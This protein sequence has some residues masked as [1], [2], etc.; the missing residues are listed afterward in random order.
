MSLGGGNSPSTWAVPVRGKDICSGYVRSSARL[1]VSK[2][3]PAVRPPALRGRPAAVSG[4][5]SVA[6]PQR[7][8]IGDDFYVAV[9]L[10]IRVP[11][12]AGSERPPP[13]LLC[14]RAQQL[15]REGRPAPAKCRSAGKRRSGRRQDRGVHG[16][17]IW[18][19]SVAGAGEV[20]RSWLGSAT[21]PVRRLSCTKSS[22]TCAG[23]SRRLA[24]ARGPASALE[25]APP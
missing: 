16:N 13:Q 17:G 8:A 15:V 4:E 6:T 23:S 20:L 10:A 12:Q 5:T 25:D 9:V 2:A 18:Q 22:R 7:Q 21:L 1:A 11:R 3:A 24:A 14:T 19:K